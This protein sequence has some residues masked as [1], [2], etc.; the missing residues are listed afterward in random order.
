MHLIYSFSR[1]KTKQSDC[2]PGQILLSLPH[3][4]CSIL[5]QNC[6]MFLCS[7]VQTSKC[8][9]P[10]HNMNKERQLTILRTTRKE[11]GECLE[12]WK[13]MSPPPLPHPQQD[14]QGGGTG[15]LGG[16]D[17]ASA[18]PP[19][20]TSDRA[21]PDQPWGIVSLPEDLGKPKFSE[22]GQGRG[23]LQFSVRTHAELS[24]TQVS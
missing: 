5:G 10:N 8:K 11:G 3:P 21:G 24:S 2:V 17:P 12:C 19:S 20:V 9:S 16:C 7:I 4:C 15:V 18:S 13:S 14:C 23:S 6:Y 1:L 22:G